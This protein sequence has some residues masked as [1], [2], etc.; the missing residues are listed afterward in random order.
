MRPKAILLAA[1]GIMLSAAAWVDAQSALPQIAPRQ[2]VPVLNGAP[3]LK[4]AGPIREDLFARRLPQ[5]QMPELQSRARAVLTGEP[6][7]AGALWVW[8]ATGKQSDSEATYLLAERISRRELGVQME[9]F[10]A[11][12]LA[13]DLRGSFVHLDR[14]LTVSPEASGNLLPGIAQSLEL[15]QIRQLLIPYA[16]RRWFAELIRIGPAS[17]ADPVSLAALLTD[18]RTQVSD[19]APGTLPSLLG[20]LLAANDGYEA[21]QLAIRTKALSAEGLEEFGLSDGTLGAQARPLTWQLTNSDAASVKQSSGGA[22]EFSIEPGRSATLL[23]RVTVYRSGAYVL[24]N[25]LSGSDVRLSARWELR[26][27]GQG[28]ESS[29]WAQRIPVSEAAQRFQ[30]AVVVPEGCQVQRWQ[31][32]ASASDLQVAATGELK[33]IELELTANE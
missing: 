26:C 10:R 7:D 13:Q 1:A 32:V 16:K 24:S 29:A 4:L 3:R 25:T 18:A 17:A 12:A 6:L 9:L 15:P 2:I 31:F 14:A 22:V 33:D 23:D 8:G 11:K 5:A 19:L 21:G 27:M 28:Q 30:A 20:S